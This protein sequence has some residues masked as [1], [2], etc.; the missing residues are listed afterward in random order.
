MPCLALAYIFRISTD[1]ASC[2]LYATSGANNR[3]ELRDAYWGCRQIY[4]MPKNGATGQY[5]TRY[6]GRCGIAD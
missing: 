1:F 4:E 3:R 6:W 5:N 2:L